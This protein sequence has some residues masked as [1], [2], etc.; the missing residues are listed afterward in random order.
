MW[1]CLGCGEAPGSGC[2]E[3]LTSKSLTLTLTL[4]LRHL[5]DYH[6]TLTP[7]A[8]RYLFDYHPMGHKEFRSVR[9]CQY[10]Q[11]DKEEPPC[12]DDE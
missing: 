11:D 2:G 6:P 8:L 7:S 12:D 10:L 9:N 1:G 4:T 3:D 5:L